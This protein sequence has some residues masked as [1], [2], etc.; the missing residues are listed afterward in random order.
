MSLHYSVVVYFMLVFT[1]LGSH[2]AIFSPLMAKGCR[3]GLFCA[4]LLCLA[5]GLSPLFTVSI[6]ETGEEDVIESQHIFSLV[7]TESGDGE[8]VVTVDEDGGLMEKSYPIDETRV[9]ED[10]T[11]ETARVETV[12]VKNCMTGTLLGIIPVTGEGYEE[13]TRIHV[14]EGTLSTFGDD[15][16]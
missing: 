16:E 1:M 7:R 2:A 5:V 11:A 3:A 9:Y 8:Y 10:A 15:T 6:V 12:T 14:P 13:E 4:G